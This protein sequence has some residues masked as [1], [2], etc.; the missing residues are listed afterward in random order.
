[1]D[2]FIARQPIFTAERNVFGYEMLYRTSLEN[3]FPKQQTDLA[4]VSMVD[5]F[6][7][8]GMEHL[9]QGRYAFVNCT[10]DFLMQDYP[11]LF[12]K[13]R[14]VLEVL[15]TVRP[16][17]AVLSAI[18]RLKQAGY[19]IALDDFRD[20]PESRRLVPLADFI[21][22]DVLETPEPEQRR[23]A[24]EFSATPVRLVSEKV[25]TYEVFERTMRCGYTLFQ[26]YFFS[27]PQVLSRH[28]IPANKLNYLLVLQAANRPTL[29]LNE[30]SERIKA[31]A[32]LSYRLLRYLNSPAF[33]FASDV[34]SIPHALRLL[35]ERGIRKWVSLVAIAGMGEDKPQELIVLP[36]IR[37]RFCELLASLAGMERTSNDLFLLGLLSSLDAILDMPMAE[38][39]KEIAI[40]AELRSALLGEDNRFRKVFEVA[41]S[42][43]TGAWDR[44][45]QASA[46]VHISAEAIPERFIQAVDW[47]RKILTGGP[48]GDQDQSQAGGPLG[49]NPSP[50]S[51]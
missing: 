36:L 18:Q 21:K 37:A 5:N 48:G 22:V 44:L 2:K 38:V 33:F 10:R 14:A 28:D 49:K 43:E 32:S 13:D 46:C 7:L 1:M 35:G 3:F 50:E 47:A 19:L 9:T 25:E 29:D 12:P 17:Q 34:S 42:Y 8:F 39:L 51:R 24:R 26:G 15:E 30:V 4:A 11:A 45:E 27:K 16:D 41:F 20:T 40:G 31:E 6:F 23:L